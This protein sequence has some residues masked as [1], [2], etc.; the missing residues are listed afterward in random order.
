MKEEITATNG[1]TG[2]KKEVPQERRLQEQNDAQ[3]PS[4]PQP[5]HQIT[6]F[7]PE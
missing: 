2:L 6:C 7:Y 3:T 4:S 5:D 1:H